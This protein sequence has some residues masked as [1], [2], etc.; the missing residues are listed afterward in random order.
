LA[1]FSDAF[2]SSN[3]TSTLTTLHFE[4]NDFFL[5]FLENYEPNQAFELSFDFFKLAF[6]HM[7]HL[8]TSDHFGMVFVDLQNCFHQ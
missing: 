7:S 1:P 3:T 5:F 6:Q 8:S 4:S 2:L